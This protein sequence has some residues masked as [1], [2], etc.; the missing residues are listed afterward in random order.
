MR[1]ESRS[2]SYGQT[3][4]EALRRERGLTQVELAYLAGISVGT[5]SR[6]ESRAARPH[7]STLRALAAALDC[8]ASELADHRRD[9]S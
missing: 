3:A 6:I 8:Q 4:L 2:Y 1:S 5:V 9:T 7:R